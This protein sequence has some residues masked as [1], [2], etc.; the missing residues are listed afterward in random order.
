MLLIG[1]GLFVLTPAGRKKLF[2]MKK[3]A[4]TEI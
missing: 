1:I 2:K 3:P 4:T